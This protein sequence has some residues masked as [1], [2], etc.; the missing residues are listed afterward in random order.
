[1]LL[2]KSVAPLSL[3]DDV[4]RLA[5]DHLQITSIKHR[6]AVQRLSATPPA[7]FDGVR[8][9]RG[10]FEAVADNWLRCVDAL[11][12]FPSRENW[13]WFDPKCDHAAHNSSPEVT[14][15]RTIVSGAQSHGR[16]DWSNQVPIA[17]GMI[18][19]GGDRRRAIDLVHW[20]G[21]DAF[22][23]VEL[24]V[25]SDNP[26]YAAVEILKYGFVWLLSREHRARLG[27]SG[28]AIVEA[29]D[30]RLSVLAPHPYY[31]GLALNWLEAGLSQ[32]VKAL[33][34]ERQE[35]RLSFAFEAFPA[36]F[37]WPDPDPIAALSALD[38]RT[39]V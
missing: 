13:R 36:S 35:V 2:A 15:E 8:F 34:A 28:K 22:D 10:L 30:V 38:H 6:S 18:A 32:G 20:R 23:F 12:G 25:G 27:Y 31:D 11:A 9:V 29:S 37:V 21:S 7:A 17:S 26:L 3:F 19:G 24:K 14:L 33:G 39:R 5:A 16:T 1:M 4:D